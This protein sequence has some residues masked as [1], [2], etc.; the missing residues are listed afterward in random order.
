MKREKIMNL[1]KFFAIG[2]SFACCFGISNCKA[3]VESS[4]NSE[5]PK[6]NIIELKLERTKNTRD[7]GGYE[8]SEGKKLK[9][10]LFIRSDNTNK[11]TDADIK[12]LE[13]EHNLKCVIDLRCSREVTLAPDKLRNVEGIKYYNI[14]ISFS[15]GQIKSLLK[16]NTDLSNPLVGFLNQKDAIKKIFDTISDAIPNTNSENTDTYKSKN[17]SILFHC[18]GGMHRTG[19]TAALLLELNGVSKENIINDYSTVCGKK[20]NGKNIINWIFKPK[21]EHMKKMLEY[22]ESEFGNVEKYLLNCGV[23][24][25]NLNKIKNEFQK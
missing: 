11:L 4:I 18:T 3:S 24:Q 2:L 9:R 12:K 25:E 19:I 15:K 10:N 6:N 14:P 5:I 16:G 13:E 22:I 8:T 7:L 23:S 21:A 17:G 20:K 1:K